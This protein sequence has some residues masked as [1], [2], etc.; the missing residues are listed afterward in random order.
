MF[1]R[2]VHSSGAS[3]KFEGIVFVSLN[4]RSG[5]LCLIMS[6][7]VVRWCPLLFSFW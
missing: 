6:C 2:Y 1:T 7:F 4:R 5:Q 3:D